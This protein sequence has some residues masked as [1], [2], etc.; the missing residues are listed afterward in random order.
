MFKRWKGNLSIIIVLLIAIILAQVGISTQGT[1]A[2]EIENANEI[3]Y[4]DWIMMPEK[5]DIPLDKEWT[6]T[7][8]SNATFDKIDGIVIEHN[9]EFIPT[10]IKVDSDK[11][12]CIKPISNY[13]ANSKY[14]MRIFLSNG[15]RYYMNFTTSTSSST[16]TNTNT[17]TNTSS[18]NDELISN[19]DGKIIKVNAKPSAGF[20]YS[21]FLFIPNNINK[22]AKNNL[23]IECNNIGVHSE[24][25]TDILTEE[26]IITTGGYQLANRLGKPFLFPSFPRPF[27]G[28]YAGTYT[29]DLG[30]TTLLIPSSEKLGRLDLQMVAMIKDSQ[31]KLRTEQI[32]VNDKVL[33]YGFSASSHFSNR[34]ALLHPDI[35]K[36]V[37][38][39]G[40]NSLPI[41]PIGSY[42]NTTLRYPLGISDLKDIANIDFNL[43]E[44]KKVSQYIFMGDSDTNDTAAA[45]D[46]FEKQDTDIIYNIFGVK[47]VPDRFNTMKGIFKQLDVPAQ[48]VLYK[49]V[50]HQG[51][52]GHIIDDVVEFFNNNSDE[53]KENVEV[54]YHEYPLNY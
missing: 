16:N 13:E 29:H 7:F 31:S 9:A 3:T 46:C 35:V 48:F 8:T 38:V 25:V 27:D 51:M 18:D 41:L 11:K 15:K 53:D 45:G 50:G 44:Y 14:V 17:N 12:V 40:I 47:Q 10:E 36:A 28:K 26:Q 32:N 19:N 2:K 39:G 43:A 33:A 52:A 30:R 34:F 4:K 37:A 23:L 5:L 20:N 22:T 42:N 24:K 21:Y 49:N 1:Y 6:V 54:K